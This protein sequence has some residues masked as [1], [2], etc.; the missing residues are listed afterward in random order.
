[1]VDLPVPPLPAVTAIICDILFALLALI[2]TKLC[3]SLF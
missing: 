1:V 2:N 3:L